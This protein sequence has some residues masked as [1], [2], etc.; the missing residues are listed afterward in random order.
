MM[1]S[2]VRIVA[3]EER[4]DEPGEER[5]HGGTDD[6]AAA[7]H[8]T[9]RDT[10]DGDGRSAGEHH[11]DRGNEGQHADQR[12]TGFVRI[13]TVGEESVDAQKLRGP[14]SAPIVPTMKTSEWAKLM[15]RS[16]P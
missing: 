11:G 10:F 5:Q 13:L 14:N 15:S 7:A 9:V 2:T 8:R 3:H 4:E 12:E 6:V 16:T 1:T